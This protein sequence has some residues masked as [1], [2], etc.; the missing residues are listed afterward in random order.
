M[1][2]TIAEIR[3]CRNKI[4]HFDPLTR[5]HL[6]ISNPVAFVTAGMNVSNLKE[7][8]KYNVIQVVKG[9]LDGD[10]DIISKGEDEDG[11]SE[12]VGS[13]E[14]ENKQEQQ[15]SDASKEPEAAKEDEQV[16]DAKAL[17]AAQEKE[18]ETFEDEKVEIEEKKR[19]K[20]SK[21]EVK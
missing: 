9:S 17:E 18:F 10:I 2:K 11:N 5:I 6:T 14:P 4:A 19:G 20:K 13:K 15:E 16:I 3:L 12:S 21:T 1:K 8:L 7:A